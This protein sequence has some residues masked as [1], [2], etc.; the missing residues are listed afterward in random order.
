MKSKKQRKKKRINLIKFSIVVIV[1]IALLLY[2]AFTIYS[3]IRQPTNTFIVE[4]GSISSEEDAD[5]YII[6][7]ETIIQDKNNTNGFE[8][9]KN[10][11][12]KVAKNSPVFRYYS[13]NESSL[14]QKISDLDV[15]I[16]KALESE[17]AV[18][19]GDIAS[20]EKEIKS[21]LDEVYRLNDIGQ[22]NI[23][24]NNINAD[25]LNKAQIAGDLSPAGS[26]IK[27]L[28]DQRNSYE[29]EL[30]SNSEYIDAPVEGM[31]SY[32][33][34][35]YESLLDVKN[36]SKLD[37][38]TLSEVNI[39]TG[40]LIGSSDQ[41]AKIVN[42]FY[43]YIA[44][45]LNS[46]QAQNVNVGD[47]VTIQFLKSSEVPATIYEILDQQD[48]SKIFVFKITKGV[49]D[50]V[51]Y[52]KVSVSI[53]WW[54]LTGLKVPNSAILKENGLNYVIRN[55]TGYQD[56]V[57]VKVLK[58]N[59]NY[60]IVDNYSSDE[61]KTLGEKAPDIGNTKKINLYDEILLNPRE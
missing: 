27:K 59:D 19:S 5:G 26:Y 33:I 6:R 1:G 21:K 15:Q 51:S 53:I 4:T 52:R 29:N 42:N 57:L 14:V 13:Q 50:L 36:I 24:K 47:K 20:L 41:E 22:L 49:E 28:I 60:T 38:N 54:S 37:E 9:I 12:E 3:L 61:L 56:K 39:K 31:V 40:Q 16:Q 44:V 34:D 10:E 35:G 30:N 45:V 25:I 17:P 7:E 58:Q 11:G 18:F 48:G 46:K 55:M 43:C 23:L 32:K 8:K 2:V